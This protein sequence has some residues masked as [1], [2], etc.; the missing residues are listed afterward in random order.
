MSAHTADLV[1]RKSLLVDA[2][3]EKAFR[4]FTERMA[5]WWPVKTHSIARDAVEDVVLEG[6]PGGRL[7]ERARSGE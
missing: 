1:I 6:R 4:V 2:P 3:V 7:Y 5:T